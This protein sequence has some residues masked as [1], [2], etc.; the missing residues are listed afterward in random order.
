MDKINIGYSIRNG[1]L[2]VVASTVCLS[3]AVLP[4]A[5]SASGTH[6]PI[7]NV[8]GLSVSSAHAAD[9]FNM[10]IQDAAEAVCSPPLWSRIHRMTANSSCVEESGAFPVHRSDFPRF[11][12]RIPGML[13]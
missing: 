5:S 10:S 13:C 12:A 1:I 8:D 4:F 7:P 2:A 6:S 11:P 9:S 3:T